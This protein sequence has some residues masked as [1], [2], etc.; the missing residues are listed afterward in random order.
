MEAVVCLQWKPGRLGCSYYAGI[1][2]ELHLMEDT[3]ESDK[4]EYTSMLLAQIS[5][6]IIII[7][8]H[9]NEKLIEFLRNEYGTS[10]TL[11]EIAS[12]DFLFDKGRIAL[13]NWYIDHVSQPQESTTVDIDEENDEIANQ[14]IYFRDQDEGIKTHAYLQMDGLIEL[15]QSRLTVGCAG[16]L[17]KHL[18]KLQ[19]ELD[20][21][22]EE[23][24]I[25]EP[26]VIQPTVIKV[27]SCD[28]YVQV[29]SDTMQSLC[30]FDSERHPNMHQ[31]REKEGLS[32][33]GLLDK[34]TSVLG[35][36]LLKEWVSRPLQDRQILEDRYLSISLFMASDMRDT[37]ITLRAHLAHIKN[38]NML[39]GR[40]RES[41]AKFAYYTI[42][43]F[44]ALQST[45]NS[46]HST[47]SLIRKFKEL[48]PIVNTM[49]QVGSNID[50]V[51]DFG[52]SKEEARIIVK[53][54]VDGELDVLRE[55]YDKLDDTLLQVALEIGSV[56]PVGL[57]AA[58]N[59]V[60]FP[61]LGYLVTLPQYHLQRNSG[62]SS[63]NSSHCGNSNIT[64]YYQR[65]LPG[66]ELQVY[67]L[68]A[69]LGDLH[70]II[71]DREIEI[72]HEVAVS[73]LKYTTQFLE[74]SDALSELD[75]VLSLAVAA[76]R[77]NYVKPN[78]TLDNSLDIIKGRHPL[79][80]L[81]VDIFI[82]NHTHLQGGQG[83]KN[84]RPNTIHSSAFDSLRSAA[85][86]SKND[87]SNRNNT[88]GDNDTNSIQ[89]VTGANFSGKSV[90]LKQ[91]GLIV[92]M[93]HIGSFV[94]VERATIG[95]TDK[96][97][98][99]IQTSETVL[100]PQSAFAF[101][102][103]QINR[104]LQNATCRSLVIIDEF[105]KACL[106]TDISDGSSLFCSVIGYFLSKG[107]QCPKIVASTH[108]H[109]LV[110]KRILTAQD[111]ITLSQ[112][113]IMSQDVQ[114][115]ESSPSMR[116]SNREKSSESSTLDK[117][118]QVVFLYRIVPSDGDN[119]SHGIWCASIAGLP[120]HT[121]DRAAYLSRKFKNTE[122]I[123][124]IQTK[125]EQVKYEQLQ[126]LYTDFIGKDP[127]ALDIS[128][129]VAAMKSIFPL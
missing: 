99:R 33:F 89:I 101:D 14:H 47:F 58:L 98:T 3:I 56:L 95:I 97:F 59:V 125:Q 128:E 84:Q 102:L 23:A 71:A 111:G 106:G 26:D 76:M 73:V 45:M 93:A 117:E 121:L 81:A 91:V 2:L 78:L 122:P 129:L 65:H 25:I 66:F 88:T 82:P 39:L 38:I 43:I 75:C 40:V 44:S 57:S 10:I 53:Q 112:T 29:N 110:C 63:A 79:Q 103:Q 30:I 68:D 37:C 20:M 85:L 31:K 72:V 108:F 100:K 16:V 67:K 15:D 32:L 119:Q 55:Q 105:G 54:G 34:T 48:I 22:Q 1:N 69:T 118:H 64:E 87:S 46:S 96:I 92:Y 27:F 24:G 120:A 11:I 49:Q 6:Q 28:R 83:F 62:I 36:Q 116:V 4:F 52:A 42:C 70:A 109:D 114:D 8:D 104:A 5:P 51:I 86:S 61:Q 90:Y 127:S 7:P 77:F 13:L 60:Y 12:R 74:I 80:E 35:K 124:R 113:E 94:P 9:S 115:E 17:L 41:K 107:T 123:E 19:Q 50:N 126:V 18:K 21:H